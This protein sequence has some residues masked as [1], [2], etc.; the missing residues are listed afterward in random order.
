MSRNKEDVFRELINK[1]DT[2]Q[3]A[4]D[5]ANLVMQQ[6][7]AET[8]D[9][10]VISPALKSLLQQHANDVAPVA[11]T[12]NVMA[13]VNPQP[14]QTAYA[15][16]ISKRAWYVA[17]SVLGVLMLLSIWGG[18]GD[19][20]FA[21]NLGGNTIKQINALPSIYIITLTFGALLLVAEHFITNRIKLSKQ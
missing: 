4:D 18:S 19:H 7:N 3:P 5:I 20:A 6:I 16:L 15:P 11:F 14:V 13:Q 12:R 21:T 2:Q 1:A 9:K 10:V 8:Q 17:A